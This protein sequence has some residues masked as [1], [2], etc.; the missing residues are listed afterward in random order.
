[1]AIYAWLG[2]EVEIV[3]ARC[4]PIWIERRPSEIKRHFTEPKATKRTKELTAWVGW[5]VKLKSVKDG[6]L[7]YDGKWTEMHLLKADDGIAELNA[8]FAA[9]AGDD[10]MDKFM[11]WREGSK[12]ATELFAPMPAKEAA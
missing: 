4:A 7:L 10:A 1:M 3:E 12:E 6:H 8:A 11:T 9:A 2:T 5:F